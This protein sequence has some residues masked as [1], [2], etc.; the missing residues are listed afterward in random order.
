M[1]IVVRGSEVNHPISRH[2]RNRI[3]SVLAP[4][5]QTDSKLQET[6]LAT[7]EGFFFYVA[8]QPRA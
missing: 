7:A 6:F 5:N 1:L 4:T 2:G 3:S 8:V